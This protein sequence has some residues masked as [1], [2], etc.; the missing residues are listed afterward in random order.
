MQI[1]LS[2]CACVLVVL[3]AAPAHAQ[4]RAA[5]PVTPG[6][7]Y[8]VELAA[9]F[10]TP[11]PELSINTSE[12]GILGDEVDFVQEFGIEDKRFTEFRVTVKPAL[13]HK[14]R[15]HYVPMTYDKDAT[16]QRTIEF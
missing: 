5:A 15:F 2:T 14:I 9:M 4:F 16:L 13:K 7:D 8:H 10:W 3:A 12:L 11:S 6:E 1:R